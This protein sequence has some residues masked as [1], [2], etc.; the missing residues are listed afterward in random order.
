MQWKLNAQ[1][2]AF[3]SKKKNWVGVSKSEPVFKSKAVKIELHLL[4]DGCLKL[5]LNIGGT[6]VDFH[7]DV[8]SGV[9]G[10]YF[11]AAVPTAVPDSSYTFPYL[12]F[13][14]KSFITFNNLKIKELF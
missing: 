9:S 8:F 13:I 3:Y 10:A 7:F 1:K 5:I 6:K 12:K 2:S 14:A 4:F 11:R